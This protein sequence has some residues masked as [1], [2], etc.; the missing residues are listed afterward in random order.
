[1]CKTHLKGECDRLFSLIVRSR[2][3]CESDRPNHAGILQC[4]HGF[5]RR[6]LPIRWDTRNAFSF[7]AGCHTFYTAR[8]LEWDIF[9]LD[10]WGI[11][12]YGVLRDLALD[13]SAKTDLIATY[14]RL[15]LAAREMSLS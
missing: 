6:Y 13:P 9:L 8:P 15:L 10:R 14:D 5:S 1:M 2:A 12:L 3:K 11:E 7:C 4:A